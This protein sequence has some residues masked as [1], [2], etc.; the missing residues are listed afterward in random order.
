MVIYFSGTGNSRFCAQMIAS[1]TGD[2]IIDS[3]SFIKDGI[4]GEFVSGKP[5]V[6]VSPT[7]AWQIPHV[8]EDFIKSANFDGATDAYF[9]MTCGSDIGAAG[10]KL[11]ELC[12]EKGLDYRGVLEVV[13][14]E[15]YV[16]MFRVP[17]EEESAKIIK[18]ALPVLEDGIACINEGSDFPA[19]EVGAVDRKKSGIVNW[20][21][22]KKYV[23][24]KK[25]YTTDACIGCGKCE[26]L[27]MLNNISLTSGKPVWGE[28]CTH[29]MSCICYCPEEAIEYGK[30]SQGKP[31]YKCAE[32]TE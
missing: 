25:F 2:E 9:V 18:S 12:K 31:R 1:K 27:C 11:E 20:G 28:N 21:F 16:A 14:P 26:E 3:R 23:S 7:Y 32:Y 29:C 22:Y 10:E 5:W 4:A 8:F 6:F 17:D 13:M 24:A 30:K 15:N 19:R